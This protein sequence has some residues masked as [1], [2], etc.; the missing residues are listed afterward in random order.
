MFG[1][2]PTASNTCDF[3]RL[4]LAVELHRHT[5][6]AFRNAEALGVDPDRHI[7]LFEDGLDRLPALSSSL[8]DR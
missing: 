5:A 8:S 4:V 2:R 3:A 7:F 1:V 6:T